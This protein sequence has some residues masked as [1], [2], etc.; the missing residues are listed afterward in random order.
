MIYEILWNYIIMTKTLLLV[1]ISMV[2]W[3]LCWIWI[4]RSSYCRRYFK[5]TKQD[6]QRNLYNSLMTWLKQWLMVY[7]SDLMM[8]IRRST[9]ILKITK[10]EVGKLN[11][12]STIYCIK[13]IE[14]I[15]LIFRYAVDRICLTSNLLIKC[16]HTSGHDDD[17]ECANKRIQPSSENVPNYL[18]TF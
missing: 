10:R 11:T 3:N 2:C 9:K 14:R 12:H 1:Y 5:I 13:I 16:F 7:I 8:M 17:N 4:K 15:D 6:I 18:Y